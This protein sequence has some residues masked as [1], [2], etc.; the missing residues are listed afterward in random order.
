MPYQ[1]RNNQRHMYAPINYPIEIGYPTNLDGMRD[2]LF[3]V[4][5]F[6][7]NYYKGNEC[8]KQTAKCKK[9]KML[10]SPL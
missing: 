3:F 7:N 9:C 8:K 1:D 6:Y 10:I 2:N 5:Q 4:D